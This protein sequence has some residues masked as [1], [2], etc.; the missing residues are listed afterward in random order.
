[1]ALSNGLTWVLIHEQVTRHTA[2]GKDILKGRKRGNNQGIDNEV[3][4]I[5]NQCYELANAETLGSVPDRVEGK[6]GQELRQGGHEG[7]D[8]EREGLYQNGVG[9]KEGYISVS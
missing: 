8:R 2:K 7:A 6:Q 3:M 5:L 4:R 1:M 9:F